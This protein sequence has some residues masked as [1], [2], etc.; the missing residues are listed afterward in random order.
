ML[1]AEA[2][3]EVSPRQESTRTP[4][5]CGHLERR[6]KWP[7]VFFVV[8]IGVERKTNKQTKN[9]TKEISDFGENKKL[10]RPEKAV[11]FTA[12]INYEGS[13]VDRIMLNLNIY[14]TKM[15]I[16]HPWRTGN[17]KGLRVW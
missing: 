16:E 11:W 7:E 1:G 10:S 9:K 6:L 15:V 13:F 3:A 2:P 17:G 4:D 12:W 14:P 8:D 5:R